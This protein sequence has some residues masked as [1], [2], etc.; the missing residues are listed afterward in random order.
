M[1][2]MNE[3]PQ[4][5]KD[6]TQKSNSQP[7]PQSQPLYIGVQF[8]VTGGHI[9]NVQINSGDGTVH[10]DARTVPT[11]GHEVSDAMKEA[12]IEQKASDKQ[13]ALF[14]SLDSYIAIKHDRMLFIYRMLV[15]PCIEN[16]QKVV[17]DYVKYGTLTVDEAKSRAFTH[18]VMAIAGIPEQGETLYR[19]MLDMRNDMHELQKRVKKG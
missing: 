18:L 3:H 2:D 12:F 1:K 17:Y 10:I 5:D 16:V 4:N 8:N 14:P 7:E 13:K 19:H 15:R 9:H 11:D 6:F